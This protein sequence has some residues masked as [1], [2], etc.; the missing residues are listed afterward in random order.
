M[1]LNATNDDGLTFEV[2][3]DA[4]EVAVQFIAQRFVAEKWPPI[5]GGE[6]RMHQNFGERLRHGEMMPDVAV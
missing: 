4:A 5:F 2:C 6:D 3:E 1:I